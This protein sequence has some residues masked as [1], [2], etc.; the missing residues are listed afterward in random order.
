MDQRVEKSRQRLLRADKSV[1][2]EVC[3]SASQLLADM[4]IRL[5]VRLDL[6]AGERAEIVHQ[7]RVDSK[8]LRALWQLI[9][10]GLDASDYAFLD[11]LSRQLAKP[12]A[13]SRDAHV[14][15]ATLA[16]LSSALEPGSRV[17]VR[18]GLIR[19]LSPNTEVDEM[20]LIQV[21]RVL[22]QLQAELSRVSMRQ[23]RR[24]DIRKGLQQTSAAR[25]KLART[26]LNHHAMEPM[27]R[28][29][30]WVKLSLFQSDWLLDQKKPD[31]VS[32]L[33]SLGSELGRLHDLDMLAQHVQKDRMYFWQEDL[34]QL[35]TVVAATRAGVLCEIDALAGKTDVRDVR[36]QAKQLYRLWLH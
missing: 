10:P 7:T 17:R 18:Q 9:R 8:R 20:A 16:G 23:L 3:R 21:S 22:K 33:K 14:M 11:G 28:W 2:T 25:A 26:A 1:A 35:L 32:L 19:L 30:R 24:R 5:Q 34:E 29:R 15:G 27:H 13:S 12:L 6:N 4:N 31:E 36:K